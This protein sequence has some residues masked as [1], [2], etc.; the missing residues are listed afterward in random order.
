MNVSTDLAHDFSKVSI[1]NNICDLED[2]LSNTHISHGVQYNVMQDLDTSQYDIG[3]TTTVSLNFYQL[4]A[5]F[6]RDPV[7]HS[8]KCKYEWRIK[9]S[10][11]VIF[12]IYDWNNTLPLLQTT[13]WHIGSTG[14]KAQNKNFLKHLEKAIKCYNK[15]YTCMERGIFESKNKN[16]NECMQVLKKEMQAK[17]IQFQGI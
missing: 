2:Q 11:G 7:L 8:G 15:Y 3:Y 9:S 17:L 13:E 5:M 12:S 10:E 1:N 4:W 16:A 14:T 6:G